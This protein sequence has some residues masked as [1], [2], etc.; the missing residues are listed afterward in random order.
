MTKKIL[1]QIFFGVASFAVFGLFPFAEALAQQTV[2]TA[3]NLD[4]QMITL[5]R[6]VGTLPKLVAIASYAI[7]TFFTIR[8][9]LALKRY[10]SDP[11]ENPIN[12]FLSY[13]AI[14]SLLI[15][16]PYSIVVVSNTFAMRFPTVESSQKTFENESAYQKSGAESVDNLFTS[17]SSNFVPMAKVLAIFAYVM[18]AAI[19]FVGLLHLKNYGDDPS[20]VPVRSI[21]MKFVLAAMLVSL[22]FAMQLFVTAVTGVDSIEDQEQVGCQPLIAGGTGLDALRHGNI[23]GVGC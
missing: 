12:A 20:Q 13:G 16:L 21:V 7:G 9:I 15:V 17:L 18:A 8:A 2:S 3:T 11:D 14:G 1:L 22:P 6:Q 23:K 19:M 5:S 10:V 4:E